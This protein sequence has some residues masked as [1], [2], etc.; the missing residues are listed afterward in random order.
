MSASF[1]PSL[2]RIRVAYGFALFLL[3]CLLS[4]LPIAAQPASSFG[5]SQATAQRPA[6]ADVVLQTEM[7]KR[8]VRFFWEKSDPTTGLTND[9]ARN[10]GA[11]DAYTVSSAASTGYA[12]AALP[13]AVEHH[14]IDRDSAYNRALLTLR[15][16]HDRMPQNH[17]WFYHFVDRRTGERVWNS[18]LSSVDTAL[19]ITGALMCGQYWRNTEV[20][21]I[22]NTLYDRLDWTWMRTDGGAQ[23][24]KKVVSMGWTPESGFLKN[25]WDHYCELMV[26]YLLGLGSRTTPL[27]ADSWTA[28]KRDLVT[29]KGHQTLVGGPIFIHEMAQAFYDFHDQ[30]DSL[31]WNYWNVS[32]EAV[33]INR[34]Y[35]LDNASHRK[36][37]APDIWGLNAYDYP[38]GYKA[39]SAPGDEDGTV[40]P[41]GAVAAILFEPT[42][43]TA[44]G[45]AMY[46]RYGDKIW[47]RYGFS[48]AFNVDRNWYDPDVIGI[49]LGMALL[50][51]EDVRT[52]LPWKLLSTHPCLQNAWKRAGFHPSKGKELDKPE[53]INGP[54]GASHAHVT[55]PSR[56]NHASVT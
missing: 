16:L 7:Q 26:V 54:I 3:S 8:A 2:P 33:W 30:R 41:T 34:Q 37:Y 52:G 6:L 21:H 14:W 43:A 13:I 22:A 48:N 24:D 49:D 27:P 44:A 10:L 20:D 53:G 12:L 4:P 39:F 29:Y 19:L 35:C 17:G 36:T 1:L 38:D 15:F 51:I 45:N 42:L 11:D 25:D 56:T 23:P 18:E 50:A 32:R 9:R 55:Q 5:T 47:G 46:A 31:G 28:W 40:S